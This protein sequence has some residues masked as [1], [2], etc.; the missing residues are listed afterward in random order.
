MASEHNNG[1]SP[2]DLNVPFLLD[3][4]QSKLQDLEAPANHGDDVNFRA[5][6]SFSKT[7]F[8][9]LNALSGVGI[10]STPYAVASGGWM[11]LILLFAIATATF[12]SALLIQRCMVSDSNIKTYPDIGYQAFGKKG[13]LIVSVLM[14]VELYL[15]ATGFLI[16]QGDN[17]QT[18]LPSVEHFEFAGLT[19]GGKQGFIIIVALIILPTVWLN[20]LSLLSYIS[21]TGVLASLTIIGSVLWTG[22]V[23]GIGFQQ[24]GKLVNWDGIPTA[25]SLFAFCYCA[26]PVFPTLYTSM[27]K[28]HHFSNVMV[29]CFI[30]C[31]V[32][33][34][35]MAILGYLMFGS[36]VQ[37]Q[38]TLNLPTNKLSS[39]IAIY[40]TLVNPISKYALMVTPIINATKARFSYHCNK[41]FLHHLIGTT[42]VIS[43]MLVALV[44][45]FFG[46]LMSL[47]G[48]FLSITASVILPCACYLKITGSYQKFNGEMVALSLIIVMGVIVVIFGT[49]T[50]LVDIIGNL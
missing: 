39:R 50:S 42:V 35:S 36:D 16:L 24:K 49:Y 14:H 7:C 43:T 48:A 12:Y 34:A 32:C 38:I 46:S 29:V 31:T 10:L 3:Q 28:R 15:V 19:I 9:G 1:G 45:P 17:L 4:N 5:A 6:S 21:A 23:D 44:V 47:V 22:A 37:S 2:L 33:Y 26:H 27:Q 20:N 41:R 13:R 11:S 25:V 8:N 18:L 40:T 30:F